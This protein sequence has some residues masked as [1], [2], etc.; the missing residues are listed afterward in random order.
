MARQTEAPLVP[1]TA[2]WEA[3]TPATRLRNPN[4]HGGG[5]GGGGAGGRRTN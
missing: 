2:A 3:P 4:A 1:F 5:H